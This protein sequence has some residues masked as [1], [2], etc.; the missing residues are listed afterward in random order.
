MKLQRLVPRRAFLQ[1]AAALAVLSS[2]AS[3]ATKAQSRNGQE[4]MGKDIVM[5]HGASAGGWCFD[6]FREVS[7]ERLP[8]FR[9]Q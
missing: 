7:R 8:G 5:L 9:L 3:R 2:A 6:K 1:G 4:G